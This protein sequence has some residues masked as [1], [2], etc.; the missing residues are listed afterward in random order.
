MPEQLVRA[1]AVGTFVANHPVTR[2]PLAA[3][4]AQVKRGDVVALLECAGFLRE[5][6]A[7]ADGVVC[8]VLAADATL[9]EYGQPLL[10]LN[11]EVVE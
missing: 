3:R 6:I 2:K 11:I 4:G 10:T 5:V 8:D 7:A 1:P 9:V